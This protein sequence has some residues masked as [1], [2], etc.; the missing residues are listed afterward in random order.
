MADDDSWLYGNNAEE[1]SNLAQVGKRIADESFNNGSLEEEEN[2]PEFEVHK[3][4]D[5][6]K[7][8]SE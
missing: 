8:L 3:I 2:H 7:V 5:V 6:W 1:H 4:I